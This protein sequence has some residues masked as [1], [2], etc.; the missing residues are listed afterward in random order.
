MCVNCY[1]MRLIILHCVSFTRYTTTGAS[2]ISSHCEMQIRGGG[3][4]ESGGFENISIQIK[5]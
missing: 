2:E 4:R 1:C 5:T 3:M